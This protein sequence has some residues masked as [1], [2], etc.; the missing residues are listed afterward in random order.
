MRK[1]ES[2]KEI[3]KRLR[4][5]LKVAKEIYENSEVSSVIILSNEGFK[6]N[7]VDYDESHHWTPHDD[8]GSRLCCSFTQTHLAKLS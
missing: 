2:I 5:S 7:Y 3:K 4:V 1:I 8:G 6:L